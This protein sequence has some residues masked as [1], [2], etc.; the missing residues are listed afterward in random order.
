MLGGSFVIGSFIL[1]YSDVGDGGLCPTS[2]TAIV[3]NIY[4]ESVFNFVNV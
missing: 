4:S 3:L 2:L 1:I